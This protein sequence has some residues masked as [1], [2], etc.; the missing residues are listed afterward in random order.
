[1]SVHCPWSTD[2]Y[3]LCWYSPK[4]VSAVYELPLCCVWFFFLA[5]FFFALHHY[6]HRYRHGHRHRYRHL[7]RHRHRQRQLHRH[8]HHLNHLNRYRPPPHRHFLPAHV[9]LHHLVNLHHLFGAAAIRI[10]PIF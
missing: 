6:R 7:Q 9:H 8:R 1:M 3:L 4:Q 10:N 2:V 5:L